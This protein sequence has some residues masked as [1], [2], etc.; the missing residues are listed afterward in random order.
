MVKHFFD[1][2]GINFIKNLFKKKFEMTERTDT[3]EFK[4][5]VLR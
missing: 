5:K 3:E 4:F 2:I 1:F